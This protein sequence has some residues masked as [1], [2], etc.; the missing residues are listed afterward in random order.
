[1]TVIAHTPQSKHMGAS[2]VEPMKHLNIILCSLILLGSAILSP[3]LHAQESLTLSE[4]MA[5]NEGPF[6]D[7]KGDASDWIEIHNSG[8]NAVDLY[9]WFLTDD[10]R[11]PRKW[12]FPST[13]LPPNGYLVVF[14]SGNDRT[15]PGAPLHTN[16]KLSAGGEYLGLFKPDGV[17]VASAYA[18]FF[19]PQVPHVSYGVPMQQTTTLLLTSGAP[20]RVY[21][22]TNDALAEA[23]T[24]LSFNDESWI[25]AVTGV[26]FETD[27]QTPFVSTTIGDS[28]TNFSGV[29]GANGWYYGYWDKKNDFDGAYA[30]NDFVPFPNDGGAYGVSNYWNG[31]AWDWYG[32]PPPYTSLT[33]DGGHPNAN[34]GDPLRADHWAIR[35]FVNS[36]DGPVKISGQL[37]HAGSVSRDW[38]YIT[39][40]GGSANSL[41]YVYLTA[42]GDGY[43][44]DIKLVA[45]S[46]AEVGP[47]L[48]PNGDFESGALSPWTIGSD[49]N[50]SAST[51]VSDVSHAGSR[52]LH[53]VA[54]VGGTT[55][56]SS[57]WQT[58]APA[59]TSGQTYTLSF[60]FRPGAVPAPLVVRFSGNWINTGF[61]PTQCGDGIIGRILLDGVEMYQK[62]VFMGTANYAVTIPAR[63]GSFIDLVLDPGLS[64]NDACDASTFTARIETMDPNIMVV[65][66]S[67]NDWSYTGA[68]GEKN[69]YYGY[70]NRT[71]DADKIYQPANFTP[72]PRSSGPHSASNYWSGAMWDWYNGNPPWDEIGQTGMHPNGA[73][74]AAEHWVIRRWVSEVTGRIEV[75]WT[76]AKSNPSG[77]GV[78]GRL[79]HN[80][81]QKDSAVIAGTDSVGVQRSIVITNVQAGD[82]IDLALDATGTAG[83]TDDSADGS[84]MTMIIRGTPSVAGQFA[85][86]LATAMR[87]VNAS[88]YIRIPFVVSDPSALTYLTLRMRYDDGFLAYLN[89][90]AVAGRNQPVFPDVPT[91]NSTATAARPDAE[92]VQF[93]SIDLTPVVGRLV[94]G[95]NVLAI[96]G[97]NR[98]AA[99]GDFLILPELKAMSVQVS[100]GELRYFPAPSPGEPNGFGNTNLGPIIAEVAHMPSEP[101]DEQDLYVTAQVYPTFNPVSQVQL[102]YRVMYGNEVSVPM[103]DDGQHG[104]GLAGDSIYGGVIP[105]TA[106]TNGQMIRYYVYTTDTRTNS[107]RYPPFEDA[108]NSPQYQ[109]TVVADPNLTSALPIFHFFIQTPSA[110][111]SSSG[112]KCS[113]FFLGRFYDNCGINIHG[114]SS[115]GFP[116]HSYDIDM[117]PGYG[118]VWKEGEKPVDD[119]NFLSTYGD[120]SYMRN[121]LAYDAYE[122][123]GAGYHWVFPIRVQQNST[124]HSIANLME[125]GDANYLDRLG[126]DPNGA[127]YKMYNQFNTAGS[128]ALGVNANAE[129]KTRKNEGNADLVALYNG[130]SLTGQAQINY[131]FDHIDIPS[132]IGFLAGHV[133]ANDED[134]C[135]KNYYFYCDNDG[136]GEWRILPWDVDLTFGHTWTSDLAYFNPKIYATNCYSQTSLGIGGGNNFVNAI[137]NNPTTYQMY[138]RRVRTVTDEQLQPLGM[139]PYLLHYE[140][141]VNSLAAR[142][143]PEAA[144]DLAKWGTWN[145]RQTL[146]QAVD[147]L[148][149]NYFPLRRRWIYN[150]LIPTGV[151]VPAQ[152]TNATVLIAAV[153]SNPASR[154]QLQEYIQLL[155]TNSYAVDISGWRLTGGI[156]YTFRK[157][158]VLPSNGSLY[159]VPDPIAFR[160]RT[161]GPRGGMGLFVQGSYKGQLSAWGESLTLV[162]RGGRVV[163]TTNSP[164]NPSPA[165]RYLRITEI[166]YHPAPPPPGLSTNAEE[167][168]YIELKN[169][170]PDPLNL[171]GVR[172]VSGISF[173]FTGSAIT[174]LASGE[175]VLV[176]KNVAA[177]I[178]RYGSS[179]R[180]AGQYTSFL[181]NAGENL[182]LEDAYGEKILDFDYN[183]TWYDITDGLGFSLVIADENAPWNTWG[184]KESWQAGGGYGGSPGQTNPPLGAIAGILINEVLTHTDLP[185]IDQIELHNP[186]TNLVDL[187]GW[188]LSDDQLTPR[189]FRIPNGTLIG[190]GGYRVFTENDFNNPAN[191]AALIPFAFSSKGDEAYVFSGDPASTNLTG[192]MHG[193]DLGAAPT[194]VSLGRY[195]TSEGDEEMVAQRAPTFNATNAGPRVGPVVL[196]EIMYHPPDFPDGT[197][198]QDHEYIELRNITATNVPLYDVLA[199]AHTWRLSSAVDF[200]FPAGLTLAA[201]S[202]L[203]A[204]SFDP[205]NSAKVVDFRSH[206]GLDSSV[207]LIG[208][209]GGKLDNAGETVKLSRP[210]QPEPDG[211]VPYLLVDEV[212]YRD[213]APWP[214]EADG[215][216][217]ALHRLDLTQYGNDPINWA[218]GTPTPGAD[219][220]SG[221]APTITV[222]P[223]DQ[224]VLAFN[225]AVFSVSATGSEPLQ[226]QWQRN[227][228]NIPGA[229]QPVLTVAQVQPLS[230]S[231]LRVAVYNAAGAT[232]SSNAAL[233]VVLAA[234]ITRQP[235]SQSVFPYSNATFTV[236]AGSTSAIRYQWR[237]NGLE[238]ANATNTS[239]TITNVQPEQTGD[240]TVAITDDVGVVLSAPARLNVQLFPTITVNPSNRVQIL[241]VAPTYYTNRVAAISSTP[242]TYQWLFNGTNIPGATQAGLYIPNYNLSHAGTYSAVVSDRFGSVTSAPATFVVGVKPVIV[243]QPTPTNQTVIAGSSATFTVGVSN[244]TTL[245]VGYRWRRGAATYT[246]ILIS[247]HT[248]QLTLWNVEANLA[249]TW[250]V[251]ISNIYGNAVGGAS[252]KATLNVIETNALLFAQPSN[253]VVSP[254]SPSATFVAVAGGGAPYGYQWYFNATNVLSNATNATLT[255]TNA[256]PDQFGSYSVVVTNARGSVTSEVAT[257]TLSNGD[258]DGDGLPD[259]WELANGLQPTNPNDRDADPDQDGMS[260]WEEYIAGTDP[261]NRQSY[262]KV[263]IAPAVPATL[264]FVAVAGKSYTVEYTDGLSP[265]VWHTLQDVPAPPVTRT[266][267]VT[268][269]SPNPNRRY[270]RI[271]TAVP[272]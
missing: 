166:M 244:T 242:L 122:Q 223:A 27:G 29:Q 96:H 24:A 271:R 125:N 253:Q 156:D 152:P 129:K 161:S 100:T 241:G 132:A 6:L 1:M 232:V 104:D 248:C 143:A 5:V 246:N 220:S 189:K 134:C 234:A 3:Q 173:N 160:A 45:G 16:F 226:Y 128:T 155:N 78:T 58:I 176:V 192:Y 162:D 89:G 177:F 265:I 83:A 127:L 85:T 10:S 99:D 196:A 120:K 17:T 199:P 105:A 163:A 137:L 43:I 9:G 209:Y 135:H 142:M 224:T 117:N 35:R 109:G 121:M 270:Y 69:W 170:G 200:D 243:L 188:F 214:A 207:L 262:L 216:G 238:I 19:P 93:E 106:S 92:A 80:G 240:Y 21:V 25:P 239:L 272:P 50:L 136:T 90:E 212:R 82:F 201:G 95:T 237:A 183:N 42:A 215:V 182:R 61:T 46:V 111:D 208:P 266:E 63:L 51:I 32:D 165:Q 53:L 119:L 150:T 169:I 60:W 72:F 249:G 28:V 197:D 8:T 179:P 56:A 190:P 18:P 47:N 144:M 250:D 228:T 94:P 88:A 251:A 194:G 206:Y 195:V 263:A 198:N 245:P 164:A 116:K 225:S 66:D 213:S 114:Q 26:G 15:V 233:H 205:T 54:S 218:A 235:Q 139:H 175:S 110:A 174:S 70:Y 44:D 210:D 37:A 269:S 7:E 168:E 187:G 227:G 259:S 52:S 231:T 172:F 268:D 256:Q 230:D 13:N 153:E 36:F 73:N 57:I 159:V 30:T 68:Q 222:Q 98:S 71:A 20:A 229:T 157:A 186:S 59:L 258:C 79:F 118:F 217:T 38:V 236:V 133:L 185:Q 148:N 22:P 87:G 254:C 204:V 193:L 102:V 67:V 48:L 184:L 147:D 261:H 75:E 11:N 191:P 23:W 219:A 130:V 84:T 267:T 151:Y 264:S 62:P 4:F 171:A 203:L 65:A 140:G 14:A 55:Q 103:A 167:F 12:K 211:S 260:N 221:T 178:S 40:S 33:A 154:D 41:L 39:A 74:S 91:W 126:L 76:L 101:L 115:Q 123:A 252:A 145:P 97:L 64:A 124:F 113:L 257:L 131:V 108:V 2:P 149:V 31:T 255:I 77:S 181:E 202:R 247:S 81:A 112:S 49:N 107:M 180:I 86:D 138:L 158:V 146:D 141:M 34:N